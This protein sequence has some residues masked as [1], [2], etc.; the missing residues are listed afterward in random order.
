ME[1]RQIGSL[2]VSVVGLGCNSFGTFIDERDSRTVVHAALDEGISLFDTAD[3]YG[4][5]RSEEFLGRALGRR[6]DDVV[7]ATKVG[8]GAASLCQRDRVPSRSGPG[9]RGACAAWALTVSTCS[10]FTPPI[11]TSRLKRLSMS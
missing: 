2:S 10:S 11:S 5:G 9:W 7:V 1:T 8:L 6:R 4:G 3:I